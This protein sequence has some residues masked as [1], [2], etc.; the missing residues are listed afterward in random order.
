MVMVIAEKL[1]TKRQIHACGSISA[2]DE[3]SNSVGTVYCFA[4]HIH[5][6]RHF[7]GR[8]R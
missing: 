4:I 2:G 8:R 1:R 6:E 7:A 3:P 5:H